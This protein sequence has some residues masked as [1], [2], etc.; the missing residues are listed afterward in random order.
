MKINLAMWDR[1]L[2]FILGSLLTAWAIAGGPGWGYMG[3]YLILTSAWG[4]DPAYSIFR[5]RTA[6]LEDRSL[7]PPDLP[8]ENELP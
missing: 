3:L 8:L 7:L 4:L 1:L 6:K 2:R 5:I